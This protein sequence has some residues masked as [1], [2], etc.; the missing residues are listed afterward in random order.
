[1]KLQAM[2]TQTELQETFT[3]KNGH[4]YWRKAPKS[5]G[6]V[7]KA[8]SPSSGGHMIVTV[9]GFTLLE[10]RMI[11]F[12]KYGVLP[13]H[14]HHRDHVKHH[15]AINNLRGMTAAQHN[16]LHAREAASGNVTPEGY[17]RVV[18]V[19]WHKR[20]KRWEV[21]MSARYIGGSK[22][23]RTAVQLRLVTEMKKYKAMP[24]LDLLLGID[25]YDQ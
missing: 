11:Y 12:M 7:G 2:L 22:D 1:M 20:N 10:H 8:A 23:Y 15:N 9:G 3:Y 4:L 21:K 24:S 17:P 5:R 25:I 18:G 19:T 13:E 6:R 14:V 16:T